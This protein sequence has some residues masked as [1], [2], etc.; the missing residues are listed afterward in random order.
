MSKFSMVGTFNCLEGRNDEM[1]AAL[2][3]Q[4]AAVADE[5]DAEVYSYHRGEG[6]SYAYFAIFCG[7][8]AMQRV[9]QTE[10]MQVAMA[11][12]GGLLDGS[13]EMMMGSPLSTN[14]LDL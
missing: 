3:A 12:F 11:Q 14:G 5:D 10:A 2:A 8:E 4:V 7:P 6:T 9:S 13:P 1:D